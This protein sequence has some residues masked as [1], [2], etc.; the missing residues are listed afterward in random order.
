MNEMLLKVIYILL[1]FLP[2]GLYIILI[3][4]NGE[5]FIEK[6]LIP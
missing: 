5:Q 3:E 1:I 2:K 6:K 4:Q